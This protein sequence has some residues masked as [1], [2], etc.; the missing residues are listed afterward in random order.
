MKRFLL[1]VFCLVFLIGASC[2][3]S[4]S[5][6]NKAKKLQAAGLNE[7]AAAFFL[8]ALQ[9][10]PKNVDAKIGLKTTGQIQIEKSLTS[11]YKA[12]SVTNY[13]GAVYKYQEALN[14]ARQYGR[15]V[16]IEIPPYYNDYYQEMLGVYLADRYESAGDLLYEENFKEAKEIYSEILKLDP[17][18]KDVKDLNL[19]SIIEPLYRLGVAA[20]D[21]DKFRKCYGIMAEV[22][23]KKTNYKD[24][25]DYKERALEEGQVT[26]AVLEFQSVVSNKKNI[27]QSIQSAVVSGIIKTND[28]FIKVLDRSNMDALIKE[29][30]INVTDAAF[31]NSAIRAGE[32]LGANMLIQGKLINYSFS[33]GKITRQLKQGFESYKVKKTDADT[34]KTYYQTYYKRVG[35]YEYTG[36]STVYSEVQYQL[37]SAETGE[38]VK[39]DVL[40]QRKS[41]NV[42]YIDYRGN[43]KNLYAG[44]YTGSGTR[45]KKG[46]VIYNSSSQKRNLRKKA[47]T[48][49]RSLSNESQLAGIVLEQIS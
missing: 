32:L 46:D 13:K 45:F 15:F 12:Y 5:Y 4:K 39:S 25:I 30:K 35:Y 41:D 22:L 11:F 8:Q 38:V 37:I 42:N 20:F 18:Y 1:F 7:E 9:R 14:Y 17:E 3:G 47:T 23:A 21:A 28:P 10:N 6:S 16:N 26:V 43:Y 19:Q 24:A 44:K 34:K 36:S 2:T 40:R 27:V 31:G 49:K 48:T 29:Q 33:G